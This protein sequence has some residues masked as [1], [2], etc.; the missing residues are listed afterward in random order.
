M[1]DEL[2]DRRSYET[3]ALRVHWD[4]SRCI[5][6]GICLRTLPSVFDTG[7]RP[8][9]D[10]SDAQASAVADALERCPKG[11]LRYERLD[12]AEGERPGRPTLIRP[13][14]NGP[15]LMA[16]DMDV[17]GPDR[18][19]ITNEARLTLCRCGL[20]HNQPFCDNSHRR[21]NWQSGPTAEPRE[22]PPPPREGAGEE[23]T[24]VIARRAA[25]LDVRGDLR[26]YL[27]EG[28]VMLEAGRVLLCRCGQ[29]ANKRFCD[30]SHERAEFRSRPPQ[31]LRERI[32]A[33]TPAAFASNPEVPDPRAAGGA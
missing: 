31:T 29:S 3:D 17:R 11:A 6:T 14:R 30:R 16:G 25:S 28:R 12:G 26:I 32:E 23:P 4:S 2:R 24:T 10:L 27:S 7:R 33:E 9:V 13:I 22:P 19:P 15:L 20:S 21:R 8:W 5:H 18:E 1:A